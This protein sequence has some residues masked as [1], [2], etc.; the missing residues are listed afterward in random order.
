MLQKLKPYQKIKDSG[1]EW[2][3]KI[4]DQWN[5][6]RLKH[7]TKFDLSTVDRHENDD[8]INVSICHYPQVYNNEKITASTKLSIG[9]CSN[10]ELEK[11]RLKKDDVLITKDSETPND[12][13]VPTYIENDFEHAVCGYHIAQLSTDKKQLT[14]NFLYRF[15]QSDIV[16]AY[17]ETESHGITRFGLGKDS[18][19]NMRILLP[20]I[21][22]QKSISQFLDKETTKIDS[23]IKNNHKL[24]KLLKAKRQAIINQAVT[25]G[26]NPTVTMKDSGIEWIGDIPEHWEIRKIANSNLM[27]IKSGTGISFSDKGLYPVY[28]S[29]G[30]IGFF[31]HYNVTNVLVIGR[32]GQYAGSLTLVPNK[33]WVTD[34][35]LIISLSTKL[36]QLFS[37]YAFQNLDFNKFSSKTAQ[38]LITQ[39]ILKLFQFYYPPIKE[40][41]E[42]SNFIKNKTS[43]ID[44]LISKTESQIQ[45]LQEY[46]QSII[47]SAVTGKID[48]RNSIII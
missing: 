19:G 22:E 12:I 11:F 29:N 26:L 10:K 48:I 45:K 17:F 21:L 44:S 28:G 38:P 4:P 39:G 9:T 43:K 14:G 23:G 15:I 25:K 31:D 37:Y 20:S 1:I 5:V 46:R 34:N 13:G 16:N 33:A 8:E 42:I 24:I 6:K 2:I 30:K 35:G 32:V 27:T 40:Q 7:T 47:T 41:K 18:I 3:G 36:D